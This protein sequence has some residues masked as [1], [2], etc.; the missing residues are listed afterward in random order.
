[1]YSTATHAVSIL[2]TDCIL[3]SME[4]TGFGGWFCCAGKKIKNDEKCDGCGYKELP[5]SNSTNKCLHVHKW[6]DGMK[7]CPVSVVLLI[8]V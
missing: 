6:C 5:C 8:A 7:D 4:D 3:S 1:M 2:G